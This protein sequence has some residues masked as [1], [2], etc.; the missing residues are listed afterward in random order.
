MTVPFFAL[1]ASDSKWIKDKREH[2]KFVQMA[3]DRLVVKRCA[4]THSPLNY[5]TQDDTF[6][7]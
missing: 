2:H 3:F 7:V 1:V 5:G 4:G 6:S